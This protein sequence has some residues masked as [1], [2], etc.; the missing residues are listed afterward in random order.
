MFEILAFSLSPF[1]SNVFIECRIMAVITPGE[2]A[3]N[4][5]PISTMYSRLETCPTAQMFGWVGIHAVYT[6]IDIISS[7]C[8]GTWTNG[9]RLEKSIGSRGQPSLLVVTAPDLLA[10]LHSCLGA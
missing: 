8:A 1:P 10:R 9:K 7:Q 2:T 3:G 4:Q 5:G 6:G